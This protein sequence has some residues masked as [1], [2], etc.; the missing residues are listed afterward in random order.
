MLGVPL[1]F[2][3]ICAAVRAKAAGNAAKQTLLQLTVAV[4]WRRFVAAQRG[5]RLGPG[6][7]LLWPLL[8]RLVAMPVLA[9]FG[10]RVRIVFSGGAPLDQGIARMLIGLGLPIMEGYGLTET[11]P[12]VAVNRRDDNLPGSVGRPLDGIEVKLSSEG[13]LLVRSPST[14]AG[15]WKDDERTKKAVDTAG[16]LA[17]GDVAEIRPDGRIVI[18]G[19]LADM[20]VLSIGEKVNP[21]VVEAEIARDPL[22]KQAVVMGD[23]RPHLIAVIVLNADA[24]TLF[25][26]ERGLDPRQP[27]QEASKIELLARI[28]LLLAHLPRY[29]QVRAVHLTLE[30]WTLE[31]GLL[32]PTL[33]IKRDRIFPLYA[34]EIG[35]LYA[36]Q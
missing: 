20:I 4:G 15:Y 29:A 28:A 17:T 34:K 10:G 33:K 27:N 5:S 36:K 18:L 2:E 1:I 24:W 9:A 30:P 19:R 7:R 23:R 3:R 25:A 16:W 22:F 26:T 12:V 8:E 11:A 6:A 21:N 35:D 31:A 32:T 14:M 13:E